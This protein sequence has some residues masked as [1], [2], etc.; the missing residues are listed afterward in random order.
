[1]QPGIALPPSL[2][3]IYKELVS[4]LGQPPMVLPGAD[5]RSVGRATALPNSGD[6]SAW[7]DQGVLLLNTSLT[8]QRGM[9]NSHSGK[10]WE[11][12]T[13][14]AIK[15][16]SDHRENVVFLLW[17]RNARN[18][19]VLIDT[20]KHFVLECAHPSPLSAYNGFFGCNHFAACN[21]YL[22]QHGMT[23]IQWL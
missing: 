7:A 1:V 16:L 5:P 20:H 3:N 9:A 18:K 15:A 14:A 23:P 4:E 19:K 8:V 22:Q 10:G 12:F 6:L 13:D 11:T 21:N 17:G 2:L